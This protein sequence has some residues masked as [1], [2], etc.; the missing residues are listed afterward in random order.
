LPCPCKDGV[1][2]QVQDVKPIITYSVD[3]I[4]DNEWY[5][6]D[7]FEGYLDKIPPFTEGFQTNDYKQRIKQKAK[8]CDNL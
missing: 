8:K 2:Y 5:L 4:Y 6:I 1:V 3:P 7:I